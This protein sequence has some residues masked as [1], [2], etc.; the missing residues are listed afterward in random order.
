MFKTN[1]SPNTKTTI[2]FPVK[3]GFGSTAI[4]VGGGLFIFSHRPRTRRRRGYR[5]VYV[6]MRV[7][8][9]VRRRRCG[10][11]D[12]ISRERGNAAGPTGNLIRRRRPVEFFRYI[13]RPSLR[14][15][16]SV[17][18]R[19]PSR[20]LIPEPFLNRRDG[21]TVGGNRNVVLS[22]KNLERS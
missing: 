1:P 20:D 11:A 4:T 15:L 16:C 3:T 21:W 6:S 8:C 7:L 2:I 18:N 12:R 10:A 22:G 14:C 13:R 19:L 17:T 5:S 9:T